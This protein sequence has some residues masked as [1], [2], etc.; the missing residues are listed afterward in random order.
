MNVR[1][2]LFAAARDAAGCDVV[3]VHV[4]ESATIADLRRVLAEAYPALSSWCPHLLF[5]Q[6]CRYASDATPIA[7]TAEIAAFPPV[8]GG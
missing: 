4:S 5:A 1:V 6:E 8:S 7:A 2:R 3:E